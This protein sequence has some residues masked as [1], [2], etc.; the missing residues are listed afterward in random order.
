M[1]SAASDAVAGFELVPACLEEFAAAVVAAEPVPVCLVSSAVVAAC[2][3]DLALSAGLAS[4][5]AE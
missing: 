1:A 2:L 5:L 3:V 4:T